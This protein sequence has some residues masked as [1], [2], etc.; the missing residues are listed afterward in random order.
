MLFCYFLAVEDYVPLSQ[1]LF[2]S[3]SIT[4]ISVNVTVLTD[5]IL[6][7]DEDFLVRL[8]IIQ[9]GANAVFSSDESAT[10]TIL[11]DTSKIF[12]FLNMP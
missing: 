7:A 8:E 6:E 11:D 4:T 9:T 5:S 2:F 12:V 1:T 10:V 3:A